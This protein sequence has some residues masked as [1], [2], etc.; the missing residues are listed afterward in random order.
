MVAP[1]IKILSRKTRAP[2]GILPR[3]RFVAAA[4]KLLSVLLDATHAAVWVPRAR[5]RIPPGCY[6][7]RTKPE[8][9]SGFG[10]LCAGR[11]SNPRRPKPPRLQRGVIDRS[12][13]DAHDNSMPQNPLFCH[14]IDTNEFEWCLTCSVENSLFTSFRQATQWRHCA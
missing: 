3:V 9:C 2:G 8:T 6:K 10:F 11:D 5:P 13:T 4:T 7:K 12:T 14:V 1:H